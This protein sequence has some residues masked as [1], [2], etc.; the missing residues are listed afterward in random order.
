MMRI[1]WLYVCL[2]GCL[3][4]SW[5]VV[6]GVNVNDAAHAT[7]AD[8]R[9]TTEHTSTS[10]PIPNVVHFVYG[11]RDPSP[12]LSLLH[13]LAVRAASRYI[14]PTRI[15]FHYY[16]MPV[17]PHWDA[18]RPLLHLKPLPALPQSVFGRELRH[19]AHRADVVRLEVLL[20]YGGIYLDLDVVALRSF[21][22]LLHGGHEAIMGGEGESTSMCT[23]A[24]R[25]CTHHDT[26]RMCRQPYRLM[27][28]RHPCQEKRHLCAALVQCL[29]VL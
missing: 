15:Y 20:A 21:D 23:C 28:C 1:T 11:L 27:Q 14:R 24:S 13:E 6:A 10:D 22:D 17:G 9:A 5:G 2:I 7:P 4:A 29:S 26:C 8:P 19:Y 3:A 25:P 12:V 16:Y 18:I